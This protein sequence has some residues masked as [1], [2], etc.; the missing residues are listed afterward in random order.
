MDT[1]SINPVNAGKDFALACIPRKETRKQMLVQLL[2][3]VAP[4]FKYKV[5]ILTEP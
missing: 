4:S 1:D 5:N 3:G 2:D